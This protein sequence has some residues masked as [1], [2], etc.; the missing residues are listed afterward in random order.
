M[1]MKEIKSLTKICKKSNKLI[2]NTQKNQV[3]WNFKSYN[4]LLKIQ[5]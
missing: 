5:L 3:K 1:K 2:L 4:N